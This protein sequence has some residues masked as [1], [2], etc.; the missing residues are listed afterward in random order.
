[1]TQQQSGRGS[2][3]ELVRSLLPRE[4]MDALMQ[5]T[6]GAAA[7]RLLLHG[8]ALV[9]AG[10]LVAATRGGWLVVPAMFLLGIV[11]THLF[12][13]QHECAHYSAFRSRRVNAA[14][15]WLCGAII[16]VPPVHFRYEHHHHH[17]FT[18][19]P[20]RD[21]EL[22]PMPRSLR[23]YLWYLSGIPYWWGG[24]GGILRRSAGRLNAEELAFLP[25]AERGKVVAE[26]RILALL[27]AAVLAGMLAGWT[28]PL[29]Y[30]LLP[31]LLAQPVMRWIRMTEHVG[32]PQ[33]A[34]PLR[35]TR[36]TRVA[37]VWQWLAWN[38][39]FH[40]EHHLLPAVPFH[41]LPRF[42][43]LLQGRIPPH[44]GY[45]GGHREILALLHP[46]RNGS[47]APPA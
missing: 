33:V 29:W 1:M 38:M 15:A 3:A 25:R 34:D 2:N 37:Q 42:H 12:A 17:S 36:T 16:M 7:G 9:A 40:A 24:W 30:W 27:Y 18:N 5:R 26:A 13:P 8:A 28:A 4:A 20:G 35:N 39:N 31:L 6:S 19:L 45:A 46:S 21:P 32:R 23:E 43:A 47:P 22:I 14:V 11:L 41:A 10:A 44:D